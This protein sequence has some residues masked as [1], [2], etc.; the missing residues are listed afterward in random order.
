MNTSYLVGI[1]H[2]SINIMFYIL[3]GIDIDTLLNASVLVL[4]VYFDDLYHIHGNAL[5]HIWN[6][7]NTTL[8]GWRY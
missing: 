4:S 5:V 7:Y 1:P 8:I 6:T 3:I 2:L